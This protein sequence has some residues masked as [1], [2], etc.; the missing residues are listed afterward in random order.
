M[1]EDELKS[2]YKSLSCSTKFRLR[3]ASDENAKYKRYQLI[4]KAFYYDCE[5]YRKYLLTND[6]R[7]LVMKYLNS[8][9]SGVILTI[10]I[11]DHYEEERKIQTPQKL[12]TPRFE[13][14]GID[15]QIWK[16]LAKTV[17]SNSEWFLVTTT[18]ECMIDE[19]PH[20]VTDSI[21]DSNGNELLERMKDGAMMRLV[22]TC[23]RQEG[24]RKAFP[25]IDRIWSNGRVTSLG[26][27]DNFRKYYLNMNQDVKVTARIYNIAI[28]QDGTWFLRYV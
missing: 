16:V 28:K 21:T 4:F 19:L 10:P 26:R 5:G 6:E 24:M 20:A 11:D 17:V 9:F 14:L 1:T 3:Q 18:I 2:M 25:H 15:S 27:Y 13:E 8:Y 7:R 22:A 23:M 12:Q